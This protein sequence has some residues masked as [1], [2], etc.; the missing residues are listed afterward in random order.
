MTDHTTVSSIY[1]KAEFGARH[2]TLSELINAFKLKRISIRSLIGHFYQPWE[3]S[4]IARRLSYLNSLKLMASAAELYKL[5]PGA[6]IAISVAQKSLHKALPFLVPTGYQSNRF[7]PFE[8]NLWS[9][10]EINLRN[11]FAIVTFFDAGFCDFDHRILDTA[12]AISI[13]DS[14]YIAASLLCDPSEVP[15]SYELRRVTGNTGHPGISFMIPPPSPEIKKR[16]LGNWRQVN[17]HDFD[18]K[19]QD[20]FQSTSLHLSFT[21]YK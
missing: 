2:V 10:I 13:G 9:P 19:A 6:T 1:F 18:G 17:H 5:L 14:I 3:G 11:A 15:E 7:S 8:I 4:N 20:S 16:T 21:G 12:M